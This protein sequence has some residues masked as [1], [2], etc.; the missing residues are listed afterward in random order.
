MLESQ[1]TFG[2]LMART[3]GSL[4]NA[5]QLSTT[6]CL[7]QGCP[8]MPPSQACIDALGDACDF[9]PHGYVALLPQAAAKARVQAHACSCKLRPPSHA[10]PHQCPHHHHQ[11]PHGQ[12]CLKARRLLLHARRNQAHIAVNRPSSE[13]DSTP[14][15]GRMR[16]HPPSSE[17][18]STPPPPSHTAT[19][20]RV[21]VF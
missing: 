4:P 2:Q 20:E 12:K 16:H 9:Q 17:L 19:V 10:R 6:Q 18:D 8:P 11:Q 3:T 13:L 21:I 7:E 15:S 14:A 5:W 1:L